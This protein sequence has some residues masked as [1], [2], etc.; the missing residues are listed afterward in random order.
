M[1]NATGVNS[2]KTYKSMRTHSGRV[3]KQWQGIGHYSEPHTPL[4]V[5]VVIVLYKNK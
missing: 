1:S 5:I 3:D 2:Q 4:V